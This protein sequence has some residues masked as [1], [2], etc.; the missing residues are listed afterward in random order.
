VSKD[1]REWVWLGTVV[2]VAPDR[3]AT[4]TDTGLHLAAE[5]EE[6]PVEGRVLAVGDGVTRVQPG[7]RVR[8][9]RYSGAKESFWG[10]DFVLVDEP[11]LLGYWRP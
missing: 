9:K 10:E 8:F 1:W 3:P 11:H 6:E 5:L 7:D 4:V 2:L